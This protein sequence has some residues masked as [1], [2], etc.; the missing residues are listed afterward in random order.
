MNKN[1]AQAMELINSTLGEHSVSHSTVKKWFAR[2]RDGNL[3]LEDDPRPV[4]VNH[5]VRGGEP[6]PPLEQRPRGRGGRS[7]IPRTVVKR[8][9]FTNTVEQVS[10]PAPTA[11]TPAPTA[12]IP[13]IRIC[14]APEAR[15]DSRGATE[16][17]FA[18]AVTD[19]TV[20]AECTKRARSAESSPG[21]PTNE[22]EKR[23]RIGSRSPPPPGDGSITTDDNTDG[24]P[25]IA[26]R[27]PPSSPPQEDQGAT[28]QAL[29]SQESWPR[30]STSY[31]ALASMVVESRPPTP[32]AGPSGISYAAA[33]AAP[34]SPKRQLSQQ[35]QQ[36]QANVK[37]APR[38]G[39]PPI[40]AECL[41]NWTRHF[42]NIRQ[43]LGHAPNARPLGKGVRFLPGSIEEFR[44]V[45]RYLSEAMKQDSS[46]SWFCYSPEADLPS[47]VAIRGLPFD[48]PPEE[49]LAALQELG[50]PAERARCIPPSK[51]RHGCTYFVQLAHLRAEE[52][53][54]LYAVTELLSMPG[55]IVEAWRGNK[56]PPQCHR[57][58]AFGHSSANCHRQ[59]KCV[60][61]AGE[62]LARDCPRPREELPTCANCGKAHTAKDRRCPVFKKEARK[63]GIAL[64]PPRP[65]SSDGRVKGVCKRP[66]P[67]PLTQDEE[68]T[69]D[70]PQTLPKPAP[71]TTG[72]GNASKPAHEQQMGQIPEP[73]A[74][75]TTLA[76]PANLPSSRRQ[77]SGAA[78]AR[79]VNDPDKKKK[80]KKRTKRAARPA[81]SDPAAASTPQ[82]RKP[83][84]AAVP[85]RQLAK[86]LI[87]GCRE[88]TET[89]TPRARRQNHDLEEEGRCSSVNKKIFVAI[90]IKQMFSYM[91]EMGP[92]TKQKSDIK[93]LVAL[94][95]DQEQDDYVR[96]LSAMIVFL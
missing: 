96:Q 38:S 53:T 58:Q 62:H 5:H 17:P 21:S 94:P 45:Q 43:R 89:T 78:G 91:E 44:V 22:D 1:V 33:A 86:Q 51:G 93:K 79:N 54:Q 87:Q 75:V 70:R 55:L 68:G 82:P 16:V 6:P 2:F 20:S 14:H 4:S 63:R 69:D 81:R 39:Y 23:P 84:T 32:T 88:N 77:P 50:F 24:L 74:P 11:P 85:D 35:Q 3:S 27:Q 29:S 49:V 64:A 28:S 8:D 40:T 83:A 92:K 73:T 95:G 52:L 26:H 37:S 65:T 60:R 76:P 25:V 36:S 80:K 31:A 19:A 67:P 12:P 13:R 34:A 71:R 41:P 15:A 7:G 18:A 72:V 59:Q 48:T 10:T 66:P 61:C 90:V 42:E 56:A 47:K 46:I 9:L 30:D 57:C